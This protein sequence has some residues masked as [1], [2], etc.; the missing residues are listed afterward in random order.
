MYWRIKSSEKKIK[1]KTNK[2]KRNWL[3]FSLCTEHLIFLHPL[4]LLLQTI[5]SLL[6]SRKK[7]N[8][9]NRLTII[10]LNAIFCVRQT[11][12]VK[13]T[14]GL[15]DNFMTFTTYIPPQT[16]PCPALPP[17]PTFAVP[18]GCSLKLDRRP[19]GCPYFTS[20]CGK[21]FHE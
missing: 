14:T 15:Y 8:F 13:T 20:T 21:L 12:C 18:P 4:L 5:R 1:M 9:Q 7:M 6:C 2:D 10:L 19:G 11:V 17:P 16:S 3:H